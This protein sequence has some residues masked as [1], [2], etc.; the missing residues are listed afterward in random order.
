MVPKALPPPSAYLAYLHHTFLHKTLMMKKRK[1]N[2]IA[3]RC[4]SYSSSSL[5]FDIAYSIPNP[6]KPW[7]IVQF[8]NYSPIWSAKLRIVILIQFG[9]DK[10]W[11]CKDCSDLGH[12]II[13]N[14]R[15]KG[16]RVELL[17]RVFCNLIHPYLFVEA[18]GCV[19]NNCIL[20][21]HTVFV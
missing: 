15:K 13:P 17:A 8:F 21:K 12:C 9:L 18:T 10:F 6:N 14:S 11:I 19:E 3:T 20:S 16:L 2:S 5:V 1:I 4:W 7:K